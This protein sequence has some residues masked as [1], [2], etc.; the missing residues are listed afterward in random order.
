CLVGSNNTLDHILRSTFVQRPSGEVKRTAACCGFASCWYS[1]SCGSLGSG[2][3]CGCSRSGWS[4][5]GLGGGCAT[6]CQGKATKAQT[7][8][9]QETAA[10]DFLVRVFHDQNGPF[11]NI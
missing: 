10:I 2:W 8:T 7:Q 9:A 5:W 4:C 1:G 11:V 3:S 6:S